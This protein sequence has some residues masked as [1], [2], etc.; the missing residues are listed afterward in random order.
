MTYYQTNLC[1]NPSFEVDLTGW[2]AIDAGTTI[3]QV[4]S[5]EGEVSQGHYAMQVI[6]DGSR[7][8]QGVIGPESDYVPDDCTGSVSVGL[9]GETGNLVVSAL[10]N[11]DGVEL[12]SVPVA[13]DPSGY[14][15]VIL[16]D[17]TIPGGSWLYI[18][19]QTPTNQDLVFYVDGVMYEPES[20]AQPY[21]D[22]DQPG[23][24]WNGA[25]GLS[26]S[27]QQYQWPL[28]GT[29]T[30]KFG[31]SCDL[32]VQGE[33]FEISGVTDIL[34][35]GGG[36]GPTSSPLAVGVSP[37]AAMTDFCIY[38]SADPD[39]AQT[40]ALWNNQGSLSGSTDYERPFAIL[41]PPREYQV[42]DGSYLWNKAA[43]ASFG[44]QWIAIPNGES[45]ILNNIQVEYP[46]LNG[47][48]YVYPQEYQTPREL[49][50]TVR[51]NRLNY[52]TNPSFEGNVTTGWIPVGAG[53]TI[54]A[55]NVTQTPQNISTYRNEQF[56][57]GTHSGKIALASSSDTG[58]KIVVPYL[59]PGRTYIISAYLQVGAGF[60]DIW[61]E[62]DQTPQEHTGIVAVSAIPYGGNATVG[63]GG[64]P[65]GGV[66]GTNIALPQSTWY[67][68]FCIFLAQTDTVTWTFAGIPIT[69]ASFPIH[70]WI[71]A[72]L[73]EE[74][75]ILYDYFDGNSGVDAIW[76]QGGVENT[77]RSYYY[78]QLEYGKHVVDDI[79]AK[80]TPYGISYATPMYGVLPTQ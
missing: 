66:T 61:M 19:V 54:T 27:Y 1:P 65:Y 64:G 41:V 38:T 7:A 10:L 47:T 37:T 39:P 70:F 33:V 3:T 55:D 28:I 29:T 49:Q 79:M 58:A 34:F 77:T 17:L 69:S 14:T 48:T 15:S 5:V 44:F 53:A 6:T 9:W 45:Q 75:D 63:Y 32:A 52:I 36:Y 18:L 59:I 2:V 35:T 42:S 30:V 68:I 13:L 11:P 25:P 23:C 20:P 21:I 76:E 12:A 74:G 46:L 67:R 78:D 31:G 22:G 72:V 62:D 4:N 71:D 51:P 73:C 26:S 16:N 24:T 80:N 57:A 50:L 43:Y 8:G 56:N 60:A 40:Y